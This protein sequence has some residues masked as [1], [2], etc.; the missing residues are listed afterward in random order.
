MI[1][2]NLQNVE[3]LLF[4]NSKVKIALPDLRHIFDQWLLSYRFPALTHM[5]KQALLDLLNA[6]DGTHVEKLARLFNH[7]VFIER[8]DHHIVKNLELSLVG[9]LE[10][11]LTNCN[12]YNN[13]AISRN[14]DKLSI[15]LIR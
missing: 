8:L 15:T 10:S 6:L 3:T 9:P 4:K 13:I 11:A 1:T 2:I 12:G 14:A 7:M 5:R